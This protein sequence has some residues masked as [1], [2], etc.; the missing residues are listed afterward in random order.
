M[1]QLIFK[2]GNF[3]VVVLKILSRS[4]DIQVGHYIIINQGCCSTSVL[5]PW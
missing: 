4:G 1:L 5:Q 3:L 2:G